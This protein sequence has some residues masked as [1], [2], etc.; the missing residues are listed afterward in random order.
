MHPHWTYSHHCFFVD[1]DD[2]KT[3]AEM[4]NATTHTTTTEKGT[5][6][7]DSFEVCTDA[8]KNNQKQ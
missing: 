4:K 5:A 6:R 1:L 2:R 8:A 3:K 7:N